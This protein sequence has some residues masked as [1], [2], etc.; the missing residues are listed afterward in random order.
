MQKLV[1]FINSCTH[2]ISIIILRYNCIFWDIRLSEY[3]NLELLFLFSKI[4]ATLNPPFDLCQKHIV[5]IYIQIR[6]LYI[7]LIN[8]CYLENENE[9]SDIYIYQIFLTFLH[10]GLAGTARKGQWSLG[11]YRGQTRLDVAQS[12][13]GRT[14]ESSLHSQ[15]ADLSCSKI[16]HNGVMTLPHMMTSSNGN[17]FRVTGHLCGE[18][19][20]HRWIPHT[21]ASGWCF[22]WPASE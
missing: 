16:R 15:F 1:N 5:W 11:C 3:L 4:F 6:L 12:F 10:F 9:I 22:L 18:F 20:C 2:S 19:T 13:R 14:L 17:I 7:L 8:L 21:K